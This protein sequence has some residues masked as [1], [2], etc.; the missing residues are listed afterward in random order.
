MTPEQAREV[1]RY[2]RIIAET[3]TRMIIAE[4]DSETFGSGVRHC[5]EQTVAEA[6]RH[7]AR[8]LATPLA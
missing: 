4:A 6:E 3:T 1:A 7:I 5:Q 2:V 8:I